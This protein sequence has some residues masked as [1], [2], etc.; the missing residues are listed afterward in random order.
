MSSQIYFSIKNIFF[1]IILIFQFIFFSTWVF[2][3]KNKDELTIA[4]NAEFETLNPVVNS[5]MAAVY[6]QDAALRPLVALDLK[7]KPYPV[8][9]KEIPSLEKHTAVLLPPQSG[10]GPASLQ[11]KFEILPTAKW[12]DGTQVTCEDIRMTWVIGISPNVSA[13][14]R[15]DYNNISAVTADAK[16]PKLCTILF[17]EAKWNF[18]LNFPRPIPA[19]IE[20]K[21]FEKYKD[22]PQSYERNSLYVREPQNPGLYDGPYRVSEIKIGSHVSLVPNE[23]FYG[24]DKPYFKKV[25][26]KFIL[27]SSSMEASLRSGDVQM[28]SSSGFTFD[29][30]LAFEKKITK[31]HLPFKVNFVPG[32]IYAHI[33]IN[34]DSENLKE[35]KVRQAL[36][37]ALNRKEMTQAFFEG[38]QPP[39][40]H[41]SS[42]FD[43]WYTDNPKDIN[44]YN[45]DKKKAMQ[46]LDESGWMMGSDSFRYKNGKKLQFT[47]SG[48]ADIKLNEMIEGFVKD[49]WKKI[50][51]DMQI[52]NYPARVLFSNI[53]RERKFELGFFS[54]VSSPN[55]SQRNVFHSS[56]IPAADNSWSG[57]NRSGWRNKE[58]DAWLDQFEN[59]FNEK[60]RILLMRKVLKA[61]TED[62]PDIPGYYRSN[63]SVIPADLKNYNM[64]GHV[65][66][67]YLQIEKWRY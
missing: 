35:K 25:V 17:K 37:Y 61:Y 39:A 59:E 32:V 18:Y 27:N 67:E 14:D 45:Y 19:H 62:L 52:K 66:S 13:P 26:F 23:Y 24:A 11:V 38:R 48:V 5:M 12:G 53:L 64:S 30:A 1:K 46:L 7:G 47:L 55:S 31:E 50:G 2:A 65:Y 49:G 33:A 8:L 16:N 41:F 10:S 28:A 15:A 21:I 4:L 63:V 3:E 42:P 60:K 44:V 34:M 40:M 29:Q 36:A 56:Q 22:Q 6:I 9:I 51:V 57:N 54:W 58:V 20:G 43:S